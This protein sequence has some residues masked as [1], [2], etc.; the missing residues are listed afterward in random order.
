[1]DYGFSKSGLKRH[2]QLKLSSFFHLGRL[3][4][5]R[6]A[7]IIML[8]KPWALR[9]RFF[10]SLSSAGRESLKLTVFYFFESL[11]IGC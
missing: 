8:T 3:I 9:S 6:P 4:V 5:V 11:N 1:M 2:S 7:A 10:S